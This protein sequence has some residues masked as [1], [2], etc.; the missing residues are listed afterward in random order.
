MEDLTTRQREILDFLVT[1]LD[2]HG[3]PPSFREIASGLGFKS[4]NG[5]AYQLKVLQELGYL[6]RNVPGSPARALRLSAQAA[7]TFRS[8]ST[9]SVPIVGHVVAGRPL[10]SEEVFEG[11]RAVDSSLCPRG[12]E[13][14]ALRVNGDSMVESGILDGDLVIVRKQDT[15]RNKDIVVAVLD[16]ET[17]VKRLD[18]QRDGVRLLPANARMAPIP[19]PPG[20]ELHIAGV[21]VGLFRSM[22]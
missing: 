10:F 17:T 2:Q 22:V 7:G 1:F 4:T 20:S 13:V 9:V 18:T 12:A 19:V 5:V 14:F 6:E 3:Y 8:T 15:A 21:V 16:G 11:S